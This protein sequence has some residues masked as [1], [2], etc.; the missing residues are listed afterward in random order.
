LY[1]VG[2][3]DLPGGKINH[4]E[5]LEEVIVREVKEET[6]ISIVPRDIACYITL[7]RPDKKVIAIVY[8]SEY[9]N[10]T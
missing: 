10:T 8:D 9:V 7:E 6:G 4:K 1:H 2:K 5:Y 3:W